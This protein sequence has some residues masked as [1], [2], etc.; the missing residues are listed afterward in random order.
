[1]GFGLQVTTSHHL[2][3]HPVPPFS[4][5][6]NWRCLWPARPAAPCSPP[7]LLHPTLGPPCT[8]DP[9]G[10][11]PALPS[12]CRS[13]V[14]IDYGFGE[15]P[16]YFFAIFWPF[17]PV[18]FALPTKRY[19]KCIFDDKEEQKNVCFSFSFAL[20]SLF[21]IFLIA[22]SRQKDRDEPYICICIYTICMGQALVWYV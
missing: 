15:I 13:N 19:L 12:V 6:A 22:P 20:G 2:P 8:R 17:P 16:V 14:S 4:Y 10:T 21:T 3:H 1:M 18:D 9:L 7:S 11:C 5:A